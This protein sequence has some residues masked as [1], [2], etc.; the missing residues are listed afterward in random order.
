MLAMKVGE[1]EVE[2]DYVSIVLGLLLA[3]R[4]VGT[5]RKYLAEVIGQTQTLS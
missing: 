1:V 2:C 3:Y 4:Y 5:L